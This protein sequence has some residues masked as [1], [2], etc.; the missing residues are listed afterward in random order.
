MSF[1]FS[2][3]VFRLRARSEIFWP[4]WNG[5]VQ[6]RPSVRS[7]PWYSPKSVRMMPSF[8]C[9]MYSPGSSATPATISKTFMGSGIIRCTRAQAPS[10]ISTSDTATRP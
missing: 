8:G 7:V 3:G 1:T 4:A 5:L 10:P 6:R 9:S 2:G